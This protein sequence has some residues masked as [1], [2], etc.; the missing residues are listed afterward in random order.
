MNE[1]ISSGED[2]HY[3]DESLYE[4]TDA[5]GDIVAGRTQCVATAKGMGN[6]PRDNE[7]CLLS[8]VTHGREFCPTVN[9][10]GGA[11]AVPQVVEVE[12]VAAV[13]ASM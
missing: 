4:A 2:G 9:E 3:F 1:L 10:A 11:F 6:C 7:P 5:A 8:K 13:L 12:P